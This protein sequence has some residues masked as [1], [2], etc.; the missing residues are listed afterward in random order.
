MSPKLG[1]H[2]LMLSVGICLIWGNL[3]LAG[4]G[5]LMVQMINIIE[6]LIKK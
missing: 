2:L 6:D 5:I 3:V 4:T 1:K